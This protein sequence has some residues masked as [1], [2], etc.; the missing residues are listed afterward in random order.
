MQ[1]NISLKKW[2][3]SLKSDLIRI[4]NKVDRTY[5]SNRI[6]NPYDEN[7]ANDWLKMVDNCDGKNGIFRAIVF[8]GKV[9][10]NISIEQNASPFH[11]DSEIGYFLLQPFWSKGI[12]TKSVEIICNIAFNKL[13]ILRISGSVN[14]LN[15]ASCQ[16]LKKNNFNRE[17][18]LKNAIYKNGRVYDKILFGKLK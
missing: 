14:S 17:G 8:N 3:P 15:I 12:M 11:I 16:V 7:A 18:Y 5:L 9:I 1:S 2:Q 4:C 13:N 10:G 6:P